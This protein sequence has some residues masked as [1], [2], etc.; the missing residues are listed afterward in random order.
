[1]GDEAMLDQ[2]GVRLL[3]DGA[4]E[5]DVTERLRNPWG[6]LHGGVTGLLV[7]ASARAAVGD[8]HVPR[9]T[10]IRYLA[11][12]REGPVRAEPKVLVDGPDGALV[13]VEVRD[14]GQDDRLMAIATITLR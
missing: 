14:R 4:V 13:Q 10:T 2:L 3:D 9:G 1:V 7:E 6:I 8:G 11:P 12:G 5:V